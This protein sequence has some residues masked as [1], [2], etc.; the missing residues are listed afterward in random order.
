MG[1]GEGVAKRSGDP[2]D[3][4]IGDRKGKSRKTQAKL[5]A[6]T[7]VSDDEGHK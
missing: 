6:L 3:R 1:R 4:E 5:K 2:G 7:I